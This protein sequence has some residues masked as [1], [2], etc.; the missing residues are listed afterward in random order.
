V[1]VS[2]R[3]GDPVLRAYRIRDGAIAECQ[4]VLDR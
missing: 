1:L 4:V 3:D 2:L